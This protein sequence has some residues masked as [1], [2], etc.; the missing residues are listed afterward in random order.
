MPITTVPTT[1]AAAATPTVSTSFVPAVVTSTTSS[2]GMPVFTQAIISGFTT[3]V[4]TASRT[5]AE[6]CG[7]S[8]GQLSIHVA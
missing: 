1:A 7:E 3:I 2:V 5:I 4:D 6:S 8:P